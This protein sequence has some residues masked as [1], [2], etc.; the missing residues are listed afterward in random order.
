MNQP[1]GRHRRHAELDELIAASTEH[2]PT[3]EARAERRAQLYANV[4]DEYDDARAV[5][6]TNRVN[7]AIEEVK[8][9]T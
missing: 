6:F 4:D 3:E 5:A 2:R 1:T 7:A 8:N 9:R